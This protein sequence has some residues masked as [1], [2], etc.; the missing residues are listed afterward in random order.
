MTNQPFNELTDLIHKLDV[1]VRSNPDRMAVNLW[2]AALLELLRNQKD[3]LEKIGL[4]NSV[5]TETKKE[6]KPLNQ[7][8]EFSMSKNEMVPPGRL[9]LPRPFGQQVVSQGVV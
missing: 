2:N 6:K 4:K 7:R 8:L 5:K 9:E 1:L 3:I